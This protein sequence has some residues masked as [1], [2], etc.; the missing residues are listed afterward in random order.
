[1][2]GNEGDA[3][4]RRTESENENELEVG[5]HDPD[6]DE[7]LHP[8]VPGKVQMEERWQ[9]RQQGAEGKEKP[10]PG[11]GKKDKRVFL[12]RGILKVFVLQGGRKTNPEPT[13]AQ[14][15]FRVSNTKEERKDLIREFL[16]CWTWASKAVT[17]SFAP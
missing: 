7:A 16:F 14:P 10:L 5:I 2:K 12:R 6:G 11:C 9:D 3:N 15:L 1:M 8:F 4:Y 13:Q 17:E